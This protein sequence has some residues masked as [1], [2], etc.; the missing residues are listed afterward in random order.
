VV[1]SNSK[2]FDVES[3]AVHRLFWLCYNSYSSQPSPPSKTFML[4]LQGCSFYGT[5]EMRR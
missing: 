4:K 3:Q 5:S 2:D 1:L